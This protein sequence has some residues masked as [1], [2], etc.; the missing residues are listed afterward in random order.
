MSET[1]IRTSGSALCRQI[2][3]RL[4]IVAIA[5]NDG[6]MMIP[7]ELLRYHYGSLTNPSAP[8][9]WNSIRDGLIEAA[10]RLSIVCQSN[11]HQAKSILHGPTRNPNANFSAFRE[12]IDIMKNELEGLEK[13]CLLLY[14]A[15]PKNNNLIIIILQN[16]VRSLRMVFQFHEKLL[17]NFSGS[18]F[19]RKLIDV[20]KNTN[21]MSI[22]SVSHSITYANLTKCNNIYIFA[23][24]GILYSSQVFWIQF[25]HYLPE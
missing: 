2:I 14:I 8:L 22:P 5:S 3:Q 18:N 10:E 23:M 20:V 11:Y 7:F 12:S 19:Y 1:K 25:H 21:W 13:A 6:T 24:E 16:I 4:D 15:I 17:N 9:E